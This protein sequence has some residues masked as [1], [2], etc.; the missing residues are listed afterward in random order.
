VVAPA[1]SDGKVEPGTSYSYSVSAVDV[2][3]NESRGSDAVTAK[4]PQ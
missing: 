2:K 3:G 1:Y 4:A